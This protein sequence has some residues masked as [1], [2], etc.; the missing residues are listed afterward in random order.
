VEGH[1]SPDV[2]VREGVAGD[3]HEGVLEVVGEAL[4]PARGA[5]K[6]V[7]PVQV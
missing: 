5:E 2:Y 4:D 1:E 7:L 6:L 3:D